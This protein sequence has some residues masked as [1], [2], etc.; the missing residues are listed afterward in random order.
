MFLFLRRSRRHLT[1]S[2]LSLSADGALTGHD[3]QWA[4][5]HLLQCAECARSTV[6]LRRVVNA[7]RWMPAA[8]PIRPFVLAPKAI[9]RRTSRLQ[10]RL[11]LGMAAASLAALVAVSATDLTLRPAHN[12]TSIPAVPA[13]TTGPRPVATVGPAGS[14]TEIS[15]PATPEAPPPTALPLP[16]SAE[17]PGT[18]RWWPWELALASVF[19]VASGLALFLRRRTGSGLR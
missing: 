13:A 7:L 6:E 5:S 18:L 11:A 17:A 4:E 15:S 9:A 8:T 12:E 1:Q 16:Q 3:R 14:A 2:E 19:A 10:P